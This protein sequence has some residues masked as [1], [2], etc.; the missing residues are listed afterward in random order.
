MKNSLKYRQVRDYLG[1]CLHEAECAVNNLH[2]VTMALN[3]LGKETQLAQ[4]RRVL[5]GAKEVH[6]SIL[7]IRDEFFS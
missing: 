1:A 2:A 3:S 6:A 5:E 4:A 7:K